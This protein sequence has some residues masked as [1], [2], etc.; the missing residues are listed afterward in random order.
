MSLAIKHISNVS[1]LISN[2]GKEKTIL[3][4]NIELGFFS[5]DY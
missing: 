2:M 1:D 3:Q 4:K 5:Q